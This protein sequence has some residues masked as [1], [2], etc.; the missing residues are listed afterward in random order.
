MARTK[1]AIWYNSPFIGIGGKGEKPRRMMHPSFQSTART[2]K[3]GM[4]SRKKT[5]RSSGWL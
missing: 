4:W 5:R 1:Y 2:G 3:R